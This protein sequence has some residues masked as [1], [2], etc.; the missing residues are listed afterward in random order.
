MA[1]KKLCRWL[2]SKVAP[3][4][5]VNWFKLLIALAVGLYFRIPFL[6]AV[7]AGGALLLI[8]IQRKHRYRDAIYSPIS[9]DELP[10]RARHYFEELTPE[11]E[12]CGFVW[13]GDFFAD[14]WLEKSHSRCFLHRSLPILAELYDSPRSPKRHSFCM[15]SIAENGVLIESSRYS[16]AGVPQ[17]DHVHLVFA[18]GQSPSGMLEMHAAALCDFEDSGL[19]ILPLEARDLQGLK[20]YATLLCYAHFHDRGLVADP[21]W[22]NEVRTRPT[23]DAPESVDIDED[24]V[25]LSCAP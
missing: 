5:V 11:F 20:Q 13:I 22:L 7:V 21:P 18:T 15:D 8:F 6:L 2:F 25:L 4:Q 9:V 17:F 1:I 12:R 10:R 3:N 16:S 23:A 14:K 24:G 19:Q